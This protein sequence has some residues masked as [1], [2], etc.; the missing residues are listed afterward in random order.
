MTY[1]S[2]V[3]VTADGETFETKDFATAQ[4][5]KAGGGTYTCK[6]TEVKTY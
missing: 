1:L 6:Y 4:A 3:C 5:C 2:Y